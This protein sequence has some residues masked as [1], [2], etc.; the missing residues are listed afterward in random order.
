MHIYSLS[1]QPS[2]VT[3]TVTTLHTIYTTTKGFIIFKVYTIMNWI[4]KHS[5]LLPPIINV[6][7]N[8]FDTF[9]T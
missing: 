2:Y 1:S 6:V 7:K 5:F 9:L 3:S 4:T 8:A